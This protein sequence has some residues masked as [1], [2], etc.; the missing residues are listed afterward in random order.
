MYNWR[1]DAFNCGQDY[2]FANQPLVGFGYPPYNLPG[3]PS[4]VS[5]IDWLVTFDRQNKVDTLVTVPTIGWVAKNATSTGDA[6]GKNPSQDAVRA[7]A[8]FMQQWVKHLVETFG[9]AD[10]GGV[11]YYQLD[12][13]LDNWAKMHSDVHP[14]APSASEIWTGVQTYARAIKAAD[15]S[16]FVAVYGPALLEA[17]VYSPLDE[18]KIGSDEPFVP[19]ALDLNTNTFSTWLLKQAADY[20][21]QHGVRVMDCLDMHYPSAGR[22]PVQDVRSLWDPSYDEKSWLT[23][24]CYH[25]PIQIL[26]RMQRWI[27]A[28]YPGTG[29]CISEYQYYPPTGNGSPD[30]SG[31]TEADALGIFGKYGVKLAAYW[32]RTTDSSGNVTPTWTAFAMYRNYDG[33]GAHF[34]DYSVSASSTTT[35]VTIYS[36]VN[37]PTVPTTLWV[38][39][40][41]KT[42]KSLNDQQLRINN[43]S[44]GVRAQMYQSTASNAPKKLTDVSISNGLATVSLP[45]LSINLMVVAQE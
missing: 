33:A 17:L 27:N 26:P 38:M 9:R 31:V 5:G 22:N 21:R 2:R 42:T 18:T 45:A 40:I 14:K 43:F 32:T 23:Q 20:E 37:S 10:A 6:S 13:E 15:P 16:A 30:Y 25:G 4:G 41:N 8:P 1:V 35:D 39:I 36:A 19:P 24:Y 44:T 3:I 34:G 28:N 29:I 11:K 12:N 7:D